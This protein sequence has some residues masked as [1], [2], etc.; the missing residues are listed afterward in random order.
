MQE[1]GP[2]GSMS[3]NGPNGL[4]YQ[5]DSDLA[6]PFQSLPSIDGQAQ[7]GGGQLPNPVTDF[8]N[9]LMQQPEIAAMFPRAFSEVAA[10]PADQIATLP[11]EHA[12]SF[13]TLWRQFSEDILPN[14]QQQPRQRSIDRFA[15]LTDDGDSPPDD[16]AASSV[17]AAAE[18]GHT[19]EQLKSMVDATTEAEVTALQNGVARA[20]SLDDRPDAAQGQPVAWHP[21]V[22]PLVEVAMGAGMGHA[23]LVACT[24][25][26]GPIDRD[27]SLDISSFL[28][29]TSEYGQ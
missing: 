3:K 4:A 9:L 14:L 10:T 18:D 15:S 26:N 13:A 11:E 7:N 2:G 1:F 6:A 24:V 20:M 22:S 23:N 29:A 12:G 5:P 21:V 19:F 25:D 27:M 17:P 28:E 16:V 8:R